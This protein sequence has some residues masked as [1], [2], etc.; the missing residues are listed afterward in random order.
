M[1]LG[2]LEERPMKRMMR[3]EVFEGLMEGSAGHSTGDS[4]ENFKR[5]RALP[6]FSSLDMSSRLFFERVLSVRKIR[7]MIF[8]PKAQA[9]R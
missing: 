4:I 2:G 5:R 7:E 8:I 1:R 9:R 6:T 3:K